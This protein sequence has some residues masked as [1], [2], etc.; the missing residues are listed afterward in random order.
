MEKHKSLVPTYCQI[1]K[2]KLEPMLDQLGMRKLQ[3]N[4]GGG[5]DVPEGI[6]HIVLF[7][8]GGKACL[9]SEPLLGKGGALPLNTLHARSAY[10]SDATL[11]PGKHIPWFGVPVIAYGIPNDHARFKL[12]M[13]EF[14]GLL[15]SFGLAS[16][17][18][19]VPIT[20]SG[21]KHMV[22]TLADK[23]LVDKFRVGEQYL[24]IEIG[25]AE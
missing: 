7:N 17:F 13:F 16:N 11:N 12:S 22:K 9:V 3:Q 24:M 14:N 25:G 19:T 23:N 4:K 10:N 5:W 15:S 8:A 18:I 20:Y 1:S 2:I 6:D 21:V